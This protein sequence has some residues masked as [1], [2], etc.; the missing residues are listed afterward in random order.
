MELPA[1][2]RGK[3]EAKAG[4]KAGVRAR[5]MASVLVGKW[6]RKPSSLTVFTVSH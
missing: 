1:E 2:S 5:V 6:E 3:E 4:A